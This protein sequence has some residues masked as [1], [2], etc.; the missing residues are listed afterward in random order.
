MGGW[1]K[2]PKWKEVGQY[3][4]HIVDGSL[5]GYVLFMLTNVMGWEYIEVQAFLTKTRATLRDK[6]VHPSFEA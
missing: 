5:E 2:D 3:N 1:P 4:L 6:S